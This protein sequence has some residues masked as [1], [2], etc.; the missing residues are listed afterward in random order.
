MFW[1][2]NEFRICGFTIFKFAMSSKL[3]GYEDGWRHIGTVCVL[4]DFDALKMENIA[5]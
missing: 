3:S 4:L 2:T 1:K 5:K